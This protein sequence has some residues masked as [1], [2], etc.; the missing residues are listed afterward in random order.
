MFFTFLD[1]TN[2]AQGSIE[3][4]QS[5]YSNDKI[6]DDDDD[7]NE[8]SDRHKEEEE[9]ESDDAYE[10]QKDPDTR[11]VDLH[12]DVEDFKKLLGISKKLKPPVT[13]SNT[14]SSNS[15]EKLPIDAYRDEI[16]ARINRDRVVIIHGETGCGKSSRLPVILYEYAMSHGVVSIYFFMFLSDLNY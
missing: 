8:E 15:K 10:V 13:S 3:E 11:K 12:N 4:S 6:G 2:G 14:S 9:E 5:D 1:Y 16:I 7:K